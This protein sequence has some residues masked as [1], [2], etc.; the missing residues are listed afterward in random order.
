MGINRVGTEVFPNEFSSGNGKP[1]KVTVDPVPSGRFGLRY[2]LI[3]VMNKIS[4]DY[5]NQNGIYR[6][7]RSTVLIDSLQPTRTLATSSA[8]ATWLR[9]MARARL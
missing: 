1:G 4:T 3:T 2:R 8:A 6:Y 5:C 9:P 7:G